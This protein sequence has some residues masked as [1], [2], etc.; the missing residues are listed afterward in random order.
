MRD[1]IDVDD[2]A[3]AHLVALEK[4]TPGLGLQLNLGTGR[5]YSVREV[6]AT[7]ERVTGKR[8]AVRETARRTGDPPR[9]VAAAQQAEQILGWR[10]RYVELEPIVASAW[11]W[12][13][14]HPDGY[15]D[16]AKA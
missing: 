12:H 11:R 14:R 10:P 8:I 1:Y 3:D 2:L 15:G 9:L 16:R 13:S 7:C 4:L 6:I 5:G